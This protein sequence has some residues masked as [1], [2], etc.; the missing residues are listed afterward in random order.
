MGFLITGVIIIC[1]VFI[2]SLLEFLNKKHLIEL[3]RDLQNGCMI[4]KI[5]KCVDC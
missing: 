3:Y 2:A 1:V 4:N 5:M